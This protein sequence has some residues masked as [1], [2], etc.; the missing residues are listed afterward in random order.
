MKIMIGLLKRTCFLRNREYSKY[1]T[2]R[3]ST[4][5]LILLFLANKLFII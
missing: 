3:L 4:F 5:A 2:M 1:V